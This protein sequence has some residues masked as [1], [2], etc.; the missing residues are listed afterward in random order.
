MRK[1]LLG[2]MALAVALISVGCQQT[3]PPAPKPDLKA[4]AA[5]IMEVDTAWMKAVQAKDAARQASYFAEDGSAFR[6]GYPKATGRDAIQKLVEV[7]SRT[8]VSTS[9]STTKL[10]VSEA[11]DMAY[12]EGAW[13]AIVKDAKGKPKKE[14]GKFLT[15][16]K[17]QPDGSWKVQADCGNLDAPPTPVK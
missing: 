8:E 13:E 2:A 9:W 7:A 12:Q 1:Q 10:V 14:I 4:E 5:K 15:V 16:W 3:P 6:E 11:A 17:K